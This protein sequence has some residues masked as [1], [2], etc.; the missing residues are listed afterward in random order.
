MTPETTGRLVGKAR[1]GKEAPPEQEKEEGGEPRAGSA[2][3][4][5]RCDATLRCPN[6][7]AK[8]QHSSATG[9]KANWQTVGLEGEM[10]GA[11]G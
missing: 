3:S 9:I 2:S 1:R 11:S 8:G 6:T 4:A 5:M 7:H 10:S